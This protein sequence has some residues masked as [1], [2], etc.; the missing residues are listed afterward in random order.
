M[1]GYVVDVE[2]HMGESF[3]SDSSWNTANLV[4]RAV[5]LQTNLASSEDIAISLGRHPQAFWYPT[6]SMTLEFRKLLPPQGARWL[7]M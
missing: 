4:R 5:S 3:S 2:P 1:L 7:F 6:L